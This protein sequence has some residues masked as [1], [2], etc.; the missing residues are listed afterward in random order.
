MIMEFAT[1]NFV[2]L[3]TMEPVIEI[4]DLDVLESLEPV[5]RLGEVVKK[6]K[7]AKKV[8]IRSHIKDLLIECTVEKLHTWWFSMKLFM[9]EHKHTFLSYERKVIIHNQEFTR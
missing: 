2:A 1:G 7:K 3:G 8:D 6:K 5:A 9:K 4:W